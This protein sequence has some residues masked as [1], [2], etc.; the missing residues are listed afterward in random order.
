M[1]KVAIFDFDGT[2]F[3]EQ[4]IP[5]LFKKWEE[6][7]Y[8]KDKKTKVKGK[9]LFK[10]FLNKI[11]LLNKQDF[12]DKAT[13]DFLYIFENMNDNQINAFFENSCA[14]IEQYFNPKI[15][16]EINA[17]KSAGFEI[18]MISGCFQIMLE[19]ALKSFEF[20]K[21][22]GSKILFSNNKIDYKKDLVI[23]SGEEKKRAF[24]NEFGL[25]TYDFEKSCAYGDSLYDRHIMELTGNPIAVTPDEDLMILAEK[26]G[27][28]IITT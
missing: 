10:Y 7:G 4:T 19:Y 27:W 15:V 5:F 16:Y 21:I 11:G 13:K 6:L 2:L 9:I 20:N 25:D 8:P 26:M 14:N 24:L 23:I 1:K 17:A 22:I 28:K 18:V 3:T 12:R